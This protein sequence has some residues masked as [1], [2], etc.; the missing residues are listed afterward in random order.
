MIFTDAGFSHQLALSVSLG[1]GVV[2]FLFAIPALFHIDRAGRRRL[3]LLSMP[4]MAICLFW[5][6]AS[7]F[8]TDSNGKIGN[9]TAGIYVFGMIYSWGPGPVP[10]TYSAEAYPLSVRTYGMSLAT[11]T[12]WAFNFALSFSWPTMQKAFQPSGAFIWYATWNIIGAILVWL[13][14]RETKGYSL[15]ELDEVFSI[16]TREFIKGRWRSLKHR[17]STGRGIDQMQ[18]IRA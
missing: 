14:V 18:T 6:G 17:L 8:I 7:F 3:L 11:A 10:F 15:E 16:S 2:N 5:T 4:L 13:V 9:V 12:T 1:W